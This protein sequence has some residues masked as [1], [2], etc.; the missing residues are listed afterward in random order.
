M[1]FEKSVPLYSK[2]L[3]ME[4]I[5]EIH[6]ICFFL[7]HVILWSTPY[8]DLKLSKRSDF[9]C[10]ISTTTESINIFRGNC[11]FSY[12]HAS[13]FNTVSSKLSVCWMKMY[14][15]PVTMSMKAY[16]INHSLHFFSRFVT[17]RLCWSHINVISNILPVFI[18]SVATHPPCTWGTIN[19]KEDISSVIRLLCYVSFHFT[20]QQ[21]RII[22][23]WT[24]LS[25]WPLTV[26]IRLL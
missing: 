16:Y 4:V 2:T 5:N 22:L 9:Y 19:F 15:W 11:V 17:Y 6:V 13:E 3:K 1:S 21:N 20:Q 12:V 10:T 14:K 8:S 26:L 24:K 7:H 23:W 25:V 18:S